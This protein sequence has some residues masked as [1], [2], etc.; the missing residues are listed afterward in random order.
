MIF[1]S[2]AVRETPTFQRLWGQW[3]GWSECSVECGR[4][5]RTRSRKCFNSRGNCEGGCAT[6]YEKC[7][8]KQ[9]SNLVEVTDWTP[10]LKSNESSVG[11]AWY[12]ERFRF[13]YKSSGKKL[14]LLKKI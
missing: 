1:F 7:E 14:S 9:C 13:S 12:E 3:G 6:Q 4:G 2:I 11:G 5:F 8:N 10:W